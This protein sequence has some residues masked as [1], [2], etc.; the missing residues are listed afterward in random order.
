LK[1]AGRAL[2]G[3][4]NDMP[5]GRSRT[6]FLNVDLEVRSKQDVADLARAFEPRAPTLSCMPFEDGYLANFELASQ[7]TDP[8]AAI[9]SFVKL[10]DRLPPRARKLWK[11]ASRR[12]L[13]I[14]VEA[15][16]EASSFELALS[17]DVLR[18]AADV[19]AR[20]TFVVYV[21]APA[22]ARTRRQRSLRRG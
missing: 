3:G 17:P 16:S 22:A 10:I 12:D 4:D 19:G 11:G 9:R 14:G 1:L 7:P 13:S 18:L 5:R 6:H 8:E 21:R 15:G 20:V 2:E